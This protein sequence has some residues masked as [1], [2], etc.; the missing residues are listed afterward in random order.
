MTQITDRGMAA[1]AKL[2]IKRLIWPGTNWACRDKSRLVRMLQSGTPERPVR[3][4]DCGCGNAYFSYQAARRGSTCLGIT[5]HDWERRNCE[6]MRDFLGLPEET[7]R[8]HTCRL[9]EFSRDPAHQE[10]FDQVLLLDVLEHIR[11]DRRCL[12]QIHGLLNE[13]GLLYITVPNRDWQGNADHLRVA[14]EE[15]GWHVRNGYT[16]EQLERLLEACGFEPVDRLRFG[17][18]GSTLVIRIQHKLFRSHLDVLTV[19]FYPF[20]RLLAALLAFWPDPHT[21]FVLARKRAEVPSTAPARGAT[22]QAN[23]HLIP[24]LVGSRG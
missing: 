13:N 21:I 20:L 18:L 7:M 14:R 3:T 10:S 12:E 23:G 8:F 15:R 4:L 17:T 5:I 16:F 11:D 19:L 22:Q 6:A 2:W 9:E 1:Q 24:E